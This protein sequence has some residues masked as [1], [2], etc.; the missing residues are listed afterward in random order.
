MLAKGSRQRLRV[1]E[2]SKAVAVCDHLPL[3]RPGKI[4]PDF[5]TLEPRHGRVRLKEPESNLENKPDG[6]V[7][8]IERGSDLREAGNPKSKTGSGAEA[9]GALQGGGHR[10]H[11]GAGRKGPPGKK[12]SWRQALRRA[13]R[14]MKAMTPILLGVILLVG[15]F[16]TFVSE[17]W[18]STVFT[19]R[20]I[21]DASFGAALGSVLAGN[22]VNSYVIG[23]G[24]LDVG[25][26]LAAVTAFILTW[27]TVGLVQIPAEIA[28]LGARFTLIRTIVAFIL[29]IPVACL[30][31]WLVGVI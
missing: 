7:S 1:L 31:A 28:A 5:L 19:G 26:E 24:L 9:P 2:S 29:S 15:L 13:A 30:T 16:K 8:P 12:K 18:I 10:G 27:V 22:P 14:Q 17:A 3:L 20:S 11:A 23:K 21:L 4:E 6:V 25:V